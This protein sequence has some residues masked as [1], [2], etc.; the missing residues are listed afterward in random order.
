MTSFTSDT[1]SGVAA[2]QPLLSVSPFRALYQLED[3]GSGL[4]SI[5]P[6][7]LSF[8]GELQDEEFDH[9]VFE[10]IAEAS[11]LH[12]LAGEVDGDGVIRQHFA[13]LQ[14]ELEIAIDAAADRFARSDLKTLDRTEAEAFFESYTPEQE[15]GPAF[16]NLFG[17]IWNKIKK[18]AGS[19]IDLAKSGV[20]SLANLALGPLLNK[21]R[22]LIPILLTKVLRFA[23]HKI[24]AQYQPI[25]TQLAQRFGVKM[26]MLT[27][28][29]GEDFVASGIGEIQNEFDAQLAGVVLAP[30]E[31]ERN[32]EVA[33]HTV[34]SETPERDP[35]ADLDRARTELTGR[36]SRLKEGEDAAP[37]FENFIPALLPLIGL[38]IRMIGRP[39][40]VNFLA[41]LLSG[42]LGKFMGPLGTPALSQAIVDAGLRLIHLEATPE[43]AEA[44]AHSA[45]VS[46]LEDTV[47]RVAGLPEYMLDDQELLEGAAL[48]AFESAAAANLPPVLSQETY[49]ARPELRESATFPGT[50]ILRPIGGRH[51][52]K[53]Y[54]RVLRVH[55]TPEK[56]HAAETF[57]GSTL[58]EFLEEQM[59]QAPGAEFEADVQL[60]ESVP[61]TF[62]P[63][64]ARMERETPGLG[65]SSEAAYGQLHPLTPAAAGVVLG[66][67]GL[68]R[69]ASPASLASRHSVV[70][71]QRFYH[72]SMPG[73]RPPASPAG[74]GR[75]RRHSRLKVILDLTKDEIRV[76]LYL[77]EARAQQLL[78]K[79]RQKGHVGVVL[80]A[81][82]PMLEKKLEM[83]LTP[84]HHGGVKVI[85]PNVAPQQAGGA[86]LQ[87]LP[88][89]L[90]GALRFHLLHWILKGLK[91]YFENHA[92]QVLAAIE[93][94]QDGVTLTLT[95][96]APPGLAALR[97]ALKGRAV[98]TGAAAFQGAAPSTDVIV[99]PGHPHG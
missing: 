95:F 17:G 64:I 87:K 97:D 31:V 50:W 41:R 57:G 73:A 3:E 79:L 7:R 49:R 5:S 54:S 66:E 19:A 55:I 48:E 15:M 42:L 10:A 84:R 81:M 71:G 12:D 62:L 28:A 11:A 44:A 47:R 76:R 16:E 69:R 93:T 43:A 85:H 78:V 59:G 90:T 26:E 99:S 67:P 24:P 4:D 9:A 36:L 30:G 21:L 96:H 6:Q 65:S 20:A 39:K 45:V 2:A 58:A 70:P 88:Q 60:Y 92:P 51:R 53:K 18:A 75:L 38:G 1:R 40:V 29:E 35:L 80:A 37:A 77:A 91:G 72:L 23:R 25:L 98:L 22:P 27:G 94:P 8:L 83:A 61:G 33:R 13:S 34:E 86:I 52:Y 14:R 89:D 82:R 56:A 68:G 32:L 46:T 74:P 63:D